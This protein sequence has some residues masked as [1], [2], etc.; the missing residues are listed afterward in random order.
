MLTQSVARRSLSRSKAVAD[1]LLAEH[2]RAHTE[3]LN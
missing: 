1:D 3:R 2:N